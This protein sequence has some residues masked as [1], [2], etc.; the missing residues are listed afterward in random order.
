MKKLTEQKIVFGGISPISKKNHIT[1]SIVD[2]KTFKKKRWRHR[3]MSGMKYAQI[4]KKKLYEMTLTTSNRAKFKDLHK[5]VDILFKRIR[6]RQPN[7]QYL[8]VRSDEINGVL[9]IVYCGANLYKPMIKKMW[10]QIHSSYIV[11]IST[12]R[13]EKKITN[14]LLT[15]Y[16][17]GHT[18][19][20]NF[21][22]L[23]YSKGWL[24]KGALV[25]WR[26]ICI[27]AKKKFYFNP[28]QKQH[29]LK[30]EPVSYI[31]VYLYKKRLWD[32]FLYGRAYPQALLEI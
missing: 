19:K 8:M 4:R 29:Y 3:I 31:D 27:Q 23:S 32:K 10:Y 12:V 22:R 14:Y 9:H 20:C 24:P 15:H 16:L 11:E 13:S 17:T 28:I 25:R 18:E 21:S 26:E 2:S 5:D 7:I 1:E 6:R 30:R